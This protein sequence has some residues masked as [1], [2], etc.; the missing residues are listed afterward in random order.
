MQVVNTGV[1]LSDD[2]FKWSTLSYRKL[3]AG[4]WGKRLAYGTRI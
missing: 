3:A 2:W 4:F 1:E